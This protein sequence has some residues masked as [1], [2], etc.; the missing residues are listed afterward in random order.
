[1]KEKPLVTIVL[2]T[3]P[4]AIKLAPVIISFKNCDLVKTRLVVTG[5]HKE[6]VDQVLGLF[7]LEAQNNLEIMKENQSLSY[8]ASSTL[9]GLKREFLKYRPDLV[10]VQGDTSTAFASALGAFYEKVPLGHV[11]AG[12][13][14]ENLNDPYPEEGNRRLI[15]QIASIHFAPTKK[16][17]L[18]LL[19]SSVT[20]M[21]E[22]TG[23]TVI[24][25]LMMISQK[26][27]IPAIQGIDWRYD[28]VIF[29]TV[30]RR[31]NWGSRLKD[32]ILGLELLLRAHDDI[33]LLISLHPN[34]KVRKPIQ[35]A[36][37]KNTRVILSEPLDYQNL[38]GTLKGCYL[39]LTDSGGIQEEAPSL[40]KPVL[41]L[42]ETT[43]RPE[44]IISGSARLIGTKPNNILEKTG[45]L[46]KNKFE[47]KKMANVKNPFGDGNASKK[48][49]EICLNFLFKK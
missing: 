41:V 12:L 6:M 1:M 13:R 45:L 37:G 43:E 7:E 30:H 38:V 40:G 49:L 28:K 19:K 22:V 35:D 26:N 32:I 10:L 48:I 42:R 36:L 21:I 24:D 18:N 11:E 46:L 3:R 27:Q 20:G 14:T 31:E 29:V 2:G 47:Y 4:E 34:K 9:D 44:A 8:I 25:S 33:I 17:E 16:S 39:V 15:S 23:N 5:Q